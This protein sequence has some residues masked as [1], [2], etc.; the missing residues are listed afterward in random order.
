MLVAFGNAKF[1]HGAFGYA[2]APQQRLRHR[3]EHVHGCKVTLIHEFGT[4]K[5]CSKCN[6]ILVS[7]GCK[8]EK[9][10]EEQKAKGSIPRSYGVLK[11]L[12]C[13]ETSLAA[14]TGEDTTRASLLKGLEEDRCRGQRL[15]NFLSARTRPEGYALLKRALEAVRASAE[16]PTLGGA[17]LSSSGHPLHWHRD[18]N[19]TINMGRIYMELAESG[20]RPSHFEFSNASEN[21]A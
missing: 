8:T 6:G 7:V 13:K 1:A 5:F 3:L 20:R 12:K 2:S 9:E 16:A 10:H 18:I 17:P 4:S 11:C 19:A 14:P 15:L 21:D